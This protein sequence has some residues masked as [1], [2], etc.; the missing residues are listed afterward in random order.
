VTAISVD[1][2]I[3]EAR[4]RARRRRLAW[5][6]AAI[7]IGGGMASA[8]LH[9]G[10]GG[11]SAA[12]ERR[13]LVRVGARTT[14]SEAGVV[15][16]GGVWAMNGIGLWY[17]L[18]GGT[19]WRT[20]TPPRVR[21]QDV[22]ARILQVEFADPQHG[23]AS[24]ADIPGARVQRHGSTRYSMLFRTTDGG[25]SWFHPRESCAAC[26]GTLSFLDRNAGFTL[27]GMTLFRTGD[28]GVTWTRVAHAP[29]QGW[30]EFTSAR[31]G[32]GVE[33]QRPALW[34]T[35]DGGRTWRRVV[36]GYATLPQH[37]AVA[38]PGAVLVDGERR[39]L[40]VVDRGGVPVFSASSPHDFMFW[41]K[42]TLWASSDAGR[43]WRRVPMTVHPQELYDL[44]FASPTEGWA[45][46]GFV[47]STGYENAIVLV[48]TTNGGRDWT[49]LT[50][51]VPKVRYVAPKPQCGSA[52]RRP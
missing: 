37:G 3:A 48:H 11:P 17:S 42:R 34:R 20:I 44:R 22:V 26:G 28:G 5:A 31:D 27:V 33:W 47:R 50:P 21:G 14:I 51:P 7:V 23:W 16:G 15:A 39:P 35:S 4:R 38:V 30:I 41:A 32:W 1:P 25:R 6:A 9:R 49:P 36:R 52:C 10:G 40:P 8:A 29:F 45:I 18:D 43:T 46:L 24:G 19:R 13:S 2:L 12:A